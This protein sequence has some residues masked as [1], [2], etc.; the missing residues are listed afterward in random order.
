[1]SKPGW[2]I[3]LRQKPLTVDELESAVD[4]RDK[5]LFVEVVREMLDQGL[6]AYDEFWVLSL[7]KGK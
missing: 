4:P 7:K 1:M 6:L 5:E 3:L 2:W